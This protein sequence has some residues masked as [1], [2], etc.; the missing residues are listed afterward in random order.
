MGRFK[1]VRYHK[2]KDFTSGILTLDG[3]FICH[4]LEDAVRDLRTLSD[5]VPG[6]TAIPAGSYKVAVTLSPKFKRR[7]T[8]IQDVPFFQGI[9]MHGG[10]TAS[11]SEGCPLCAKNYIEP[12]HIQGSMEREITALVDAGKASWIDIVEV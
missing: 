9:R 3:Q 6:K 4:T 10:N 7:M 11:D 1:L 12:G 8:L 2:A 5:K